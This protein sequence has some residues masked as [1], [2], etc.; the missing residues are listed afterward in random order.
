MKSA[1]LLALI[2]VVYTG[3]P[4][5]YNLKWSDEFEG[6]SID[7]SKWT[8]DLG[9][10]GWG[11]NELEHYTN[12]G[13]NAYVSGGMLHIKAKKE[14]YQGSQYTSARMKTKG[15]FEFQY[16]YVEARIALPRGNGIWP[17]FWMLGENIDSVSWPTCGEIDII[18]AINTENKVYAT[19]HWFSNGGH[20]DYGT[21]TGNFDV[22]QFHTY[23]L[24]W[25]GYSIR[26]GVD[27][28]QHY[29][30]IIKDSVGNTGAFHKRFFFLLNIAIGGNWPGFNIDN[31]KLP[32]EMLVDYIRVYQP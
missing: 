15:K 17:A 27:G 22:T 1:L 6:N 25:D 20:A 2:V 7:S 4:A 16:G 28:N 18:E 24:H 11:N 30:M 19:C 14:D 10:G 9:A 8:Y 5:G 13:E 21:S 12:R 31:S 26:I 32:A 29:E 23:Y 3:V